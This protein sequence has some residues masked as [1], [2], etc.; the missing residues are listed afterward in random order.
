MCRLSRNLGVSTSWNPQGLSRPLMGLLY[1]FTVTVYQDITPKIA[2]LLAETCGWRYYSESTPI[3]LR[4]LCWS[5]MRLG[6]LTNS[7][8]LVLL[9][10][11]F[12]HILVHCLAIKELKLSY[13]ALHPQGALGRSVLFWNEKCRLLPIVPNFTLILCFGWFYLSF[14]VN[15]LFPFP[16]LLELIIFTR[17]AMCWWL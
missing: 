8:S 6:H 14:L 1:L 7:V 5:L 4:P 3:K 15:C 13:H 12:S 11:L 10:P 16:F 17:R 2:G 9:L